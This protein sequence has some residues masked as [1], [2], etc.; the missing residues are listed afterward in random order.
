MNSPL[1]LALPLDIKEHDFNRVEL[2]LEI[3]FSNIYYF[4]K[5]KPL[6]FFPLYAGS[7]KPLYAGSFKH[8]RTGL[9]ETYHDIDIL[10]NK[11]LK[12]D[13]EEV[14]KNTKAIRRTMYLGS[15]KFKHGIMSNVFYL[16]VQN[17][18]IHPTQVDFIFVDFERLP[19]KL[20]IEVPTD[21]SYFSHSCSPSDMKFG[22]KGVFHK[23]LINS[24]LTSHDDESNKIQYRFS[25]MSGMR[26]KEF[27]NSKTS[28]SKDLNIIFNTMF[29]T[30][31]PNDE[32]ENCYSFVG[33]IYLMTKYFDTNKLDTI[34][35]I[36]YEHCCGNKARQIDKDITQDYI[37][38]QKAI[39][40]LEAEI[41]KKKLEE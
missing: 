35:Q 14:F 24:I 17:N 2:S 10:V 33:L 29:G 23:Y 22:I 9:K 8:W 27:T 21:F 20:F 40:Y 1:E 12:K 7:F 16:E 6:G 26:N 15:G 38:K 5:N 11:N 19:F 34:A 13:I 18:I 32:I 37:I 25:V 3:L 28:Y 39:E 4:L 31:L 41:T 36:F 30:T